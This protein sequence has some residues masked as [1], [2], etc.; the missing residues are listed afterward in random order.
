[1]GGLHQGPGPKLE[2]FGWWNPLI[3]LSKC[4][5][6]LPVQDVTCD[7]EVVWV[8]WVEA[9]GGMDIDASADVMSE[10]TR[11]IRRQNP[12]TI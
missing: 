5:I 7:E 9:D 6:N 8:M 2:W 1:M 11:Q 10:S 12:A 3:Y 4:F